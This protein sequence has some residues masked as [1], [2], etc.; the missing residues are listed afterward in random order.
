MTF[1]IFNEK[2]KHFLVPMVPTQT[3]TAKQM[4]DFSGIGFTD[5]DLIIDCIKVYV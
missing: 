3:N 1:L 5:C 4:C 2:E